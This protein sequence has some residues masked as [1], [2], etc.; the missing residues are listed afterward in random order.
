MVLCRNAQSRR[1]RDQKQ[2]LN[3]VGA[4]RQLEFQNPPE[5]G[6]GAYYEINGVARPSE[7]HGTPRA[8]LDGAP[9][10]DLNSVSER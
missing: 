5:M 9:R 4:S 1:R 2:D 8:E 7:L 10:R 3:G 6:E